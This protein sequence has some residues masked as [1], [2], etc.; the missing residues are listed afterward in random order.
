MP[1][2]DT[3]HRYRRE[4]VEDGDGCYW[5]HW[6]NDGFTSCLPPSSSFAHS[7]HSTHTCR[8]VVP[9]TP[10]VA[11][12]TPVRAPS[13]RPG[14]AHHRSSSTTNGP[15]SGT[16]SARRSPDRH[17]HSRTPPPRSHQAHHRSSSTTNG[18]SNGA[19][20]NRRVDNRDR[21]PEQPPVDYRALYEA[22]I[23]HDKLQ[24]QKKR[25]R[26]DKLV[27]TQSMGRGIRKVAVMFGEISAVIT[28]AEEYALNPYPEDEP[29]DKQEDEDNED[30]EPRE[31]PELTEEQ[32]QYLFDKRRNLESF[33][34][35]KRIIPNLTKRLQ[36]SDAEDL[37]HFYG[38]IQKGANGACSDDV[39]RVSICM[40]NW[41]N[42]DR[43][44]PALESFHLGIDAGSSINKPRLY[45]PETC[46]QMSTTLHRF[47]MTK[48][49]QSVRGRLYSSLEIA[50]IEVSSMIL[51][52]AYCLRLST[53]G[54]E[55]RE[56][57][58]SLSPDPNAA[59][60]NSS[61][62]CR[63][64]YADFDGAPDAI[65]TGF[66]QSRYLVK[67]YKAVFTAPSSAEQDENTHPAK[68]AK[69]SQKPT[70]RSVADILNMNG[71]VTGR[72]LA[73][74]AVLEHF[75]LTNATSWVDQYYGI[76]Y[77]QMYNFI[78]DFFETP[79]ASTAAKQRADKLLEW[80]NKQIFPGHAASAGTQRTA[81]S[82]S[83]KL[84]AQRAAM[85]T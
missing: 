21:E 80:W 79:Y 69:T 41:L 37:I 52:A 24:K 66:L 12:L 30:E 64:F 45:Q 9:A 43:D 57:L 27:S 10:V 58:R 50:A 26:D 61:F 53:A 35:M 60:L 68:K 82:S 22:R 72:S 3:A 39:R 31:P 49:T 81:V 14:L 11:P 15:S 85:E 83:A 78:V 70:R 59:V 51:Q 34:Q 84:R 8:L 18:S 54:I 20:S 62:Y 28:D 38:A 47:K 36:D 40:G 65:E 77:P 63:L 4:E 2:V 29:E 7:A 23:A 42:E 44:L 13:P 33:N 6:L 76:S 25:K 46:F 71:K 55:I 74:V 67:L 1:E 32:E 5:D 19:P 16:P 17:A 73:Y 48:D 75:S 56:E